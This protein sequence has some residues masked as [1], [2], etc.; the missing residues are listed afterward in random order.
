MA[1]R[2]G[3][4]VFIGMLILIAPAQA[5][6]SDYAIITAENIRDLQ[7]V[8]QIDFASLPD[9]LVSA[10]GLFVISSDASKIITFGNEPGQ[11]PLSRAILWGDGEEA[12]VMPI[13]DSSIFRVLSGDG[14]CL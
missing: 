8:Q 12:A 14:A 11:P 5:Q 2:L 6:Q 7:P 13:A 9:G 10:S 3:I 1:K 4:V